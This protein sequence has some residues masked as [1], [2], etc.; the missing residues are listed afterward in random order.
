[1][2]AAIWGLQFTASVALTVGTPAYQGGSYSL[3]HGGSASSCRS[4][5]DDL[6]VLH[7]RLRAVYDTQDSHENL[8]DDILGG[9]PGD[10]FRQGASLAKHDIWVLVNKVH[11]TEHALR[12]LAK[13]MDHLDDVLLPRV[14]RLGKSLVQGDQLVVPDPPATTLTPPPSLLAPNAPHAVDPT[15]AIAAWVRA[16]NYWYSAQV[17]FYEAVGSAIATSMVVLDDPAGTL[18]TIPPKRIELPHHEPLDP[19]PPFPKDRDFTTPPGEPPTTTPTPPTSAPG[20]DTPPADIGGGG[21]GLPTGDEGAPGGGHVQH[22]HQHQPPHHDPGLTPEQRHLLR[23][24]LQMHRHEVHELQHQLAQLQKDAPEPGDPTAAAYHAQVH[25]LQTQIRLHQEQIA[26]F[27]HELHPHAGD[28]GHE[29]HGAHPGHLAAEQQSLQVRDGAGLGDEDATADVLQ[30]ASG[31]GADPGGPATDPAT[32]PASSTGSGTVPTDGS[33][34]TPDPLTP[35][36]GPAD[37]APTVA[38]AGPARA[39]LA[40][41]LGGTEQS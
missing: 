23:Q 13:D 32:D 41:R 11:R 19:L 16:H 5:A 1:M 20:Q 25:A 4:T 10:D 2:T 8:P 7:K 35:G 9:T 40:A 3:V 26:T 28:H 33:A 39:R 22:Q 34:G 29:S 12:Q 15:P 14:R 24:Q 6:R 38:D 36:P 27:Q 30:P 21:G 37:P 31:D 18:F 17:A